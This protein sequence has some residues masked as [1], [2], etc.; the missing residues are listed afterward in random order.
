MKKCLSIAIGPRANTIR[1]STFARA[2]VN[3]SRRVLFCNGLT[4]KSRCE[5]NVLL[6][7]ERRQEQHAHFHVV[8]AKSILTRFGRPYD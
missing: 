3:F 2:R 8:F 6:F 7:S 1:R 4:A 5:H